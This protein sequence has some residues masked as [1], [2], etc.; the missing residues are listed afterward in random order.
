MAFQGDTFQLDAF[1]FTANGY[2]QAQARIISFGVNQS[3]QAQ[4]FIAFRVGSGLAQAYTLHFT[5]EL[6][7]ANSFGGN[8]TPALDYQPATFQLA[9]A[10]GHIIVRN[11][12]GYGQTLAFIDKSKGL[13]QAQ[14]DIKQIYRI[15]AQAQARLYS[16]NFPQFGQAQTQIGSWNYGQAQAYL[17]GIA[18]DAATFSTSSSFTHT[19]IG[20]P[21]GIVLLATGPSSGGGISSVTY[22]GVSLTVVRQDAL[23]STALSQSGIWFLGSNI[24]TGP[25]TVALSGISGYSE[26]TVISFTAV[27]DIKVRDSNGDAQPF[28]AG[29]VSR[30]LSYAGLLSQ[31]VIAGA[32][33]NSGSAITG[34]TQLAAGGHFNGAYWHGY[35]TVPSQSDFAAG[36]N[37]GGSVYC[38]TVA[39]FTQAEISTLSAYSQ[40]QAKIKVFGVNQYAQAQAYVGHFQFA[41]AQADILAT[42]N[43]FGQALAYIGHFQPAQAQAMIVQTYQSYAQAQTYIGHFKSGQA[44]ARIIAFGVNQFAQAN[45]FINAKLVFAQAQ[46]DIK[47]TYRGFAQANALIGT[48]VFAQAQAKMNSFDYPQFGQANADIVTTYQKYGQAKAWIIPPTVIAN[49][50]A[51]I[52]Q[53]YRA[54]SNAKAWIIPPTVI[55]Q[56]NAR[57]IVFGRNDFAQA[58]ADIKAISFVSANAKAQ[59]HKSAGYGLAQADILTSRNWARGQAKAYINNKNVWGQAEAFISKSKGLGQAQ[60]DIKVKAYG[61][62]Q[63]N[64][65]IKQTKFSGLAQAT[66]DIK[67]TYQYY[68]SAQALIDDRFGLGQ[69]SVVIL[70]TE[71]SYAQA[72]ARIKQTY[73]PLAQAQ[74][75]IHIRYYVNA[76]A[77]ARIHVRYNQSGQ[78]QAYINHFKWA[79]AQARILAFNVPRVGLAQGYILANIYVPPITPSSDYHTYL[80]RYNDYDLPGYAQEESYAS[81]M[82][83]N[84]YVAAYRDFSLAE[85]IG[86]QNKSID[87]RMRAWEPTYLQVKEKILRAATMLRSSKG[88]AKLY[89]QKPDAYMLALV[90]K[91]SI[92]K[93]VTQ[94][95]RILD[96]I[97]S[98]EAKPW[99]ISNETFEFSGT[100][101]IITTGRTL[102]DGG[103][104]PTILTVSG[105]NVVISGLTEYGQDTGTIEISGTCTNLVIDTEQFTATENGVNKN[106]I[107]VTKNYALYVGPGETTFTITGATSCTIQYQNRWNLASSKGRN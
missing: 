76:Q 79:Q 84:T 37:V 20:T 21:R 11:I 106:S 28:G 80:V 34:E 101:S 24:P 86:L 83:V 58:N 40:A 105:T 16:F 81:I 50:Q 22:G 46:A 104:T 102:D 67:Q 69:A 2:S 8:I 95:N 49:A 107:V 75:M 70:R 26:W 72:L 93:D 68:G 62:A 33:H 78:A 99:I 53:T 1:Q 18:F 66:A 45:A 92:Q 14:A 85:Y 57:I 36:L 59:I 60:A 25:Q 13:G 87:L 65:H 17:P 54:Y 41:Q 42:S 91:I 32:P 96:Y 55:A 43:K 77:Q 63:A 35:Q 89:I 12:N 48:Q 98:F 97:V 38:Y 51:D 31:A 94:S 74:S 9:Q 27:R 73:V 52:K 19:P 29:V 3:A 4:T 6:G 15:F 56:A 7:T 10:Q 103:W 44:Q 61:W 100:F 71:N 90:Q 82:S 47:Q 30:T 5:A 64:A 88:F 39:A 23:G